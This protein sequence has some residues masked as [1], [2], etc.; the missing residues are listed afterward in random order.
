VSL[1]DLNTGGTLDVQTGQLTLGGAF[2]SHRHEQRDGRHG[3]R[4]R[5]GARAAALSALVGRALVNLTAVT[6]NLA[7]QQHHRRGLVKVNGGG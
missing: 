1:I 5:V 6:A 3:E 4:G 2:Q 7:A